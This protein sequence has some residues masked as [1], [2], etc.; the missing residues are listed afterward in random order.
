MARSGGQTFVE[1]HSDNLILR[2]ARHVAEGDL[3]PDDVAVFWVDDSG[4]KRV[5]HIN[6]REDGSFEP[7]WP[8]G[9]FPQRHEESLALARAAFGDRPA[10]F[11]QLEFRY[12]EER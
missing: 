9:F 7:D 3:G 11:D 5:R 4:E 10:V 12:P 6:I 8:G 1:T 2:I